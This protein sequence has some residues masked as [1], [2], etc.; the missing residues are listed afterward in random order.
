LA[1]SARIPRPLSFIIARVLTNLIM[2]V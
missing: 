2:I 1:M